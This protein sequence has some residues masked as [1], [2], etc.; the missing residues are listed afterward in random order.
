MSNEAQRTEGKRVRRKVDLSASSHHHGRS[1]CLDETEA[2]REKHHSSSTP[3][4]ERT[5]V[6]ARRR[7]SSDGGVASSVVVCSK[8]VNLSRPN[9]LSL[10]L[11]V[12]RCCRCRRFCVCFAPAVPFSVFTMEPF[13]PAI[14]S[15][16]RCCPKMPGTLVHASK[17]GKAQIK[18]RHPWPMECRNK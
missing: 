17:K 1:H 12:G 18:C 15:R 9:L 11:V 13:L 7:K 16:V 6:C 10:V 14:F 8:A 2:A 3:R 5:T 4:R